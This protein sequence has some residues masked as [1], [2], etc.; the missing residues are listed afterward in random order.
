MLLADTLG[1][2]KRYIKKDGKTVLM[3]YKTTFNFVQEYPYGLLE[4]GVNQLR[5]D[6]LANKIGGTPHG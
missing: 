6:H 2:S 5:L 4:L 3:P 1:Q